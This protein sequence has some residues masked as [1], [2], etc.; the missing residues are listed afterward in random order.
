V[1]IFVHLIANGDVASLVLFGSLLVLVFAGM[2]SI[3][4]KRKKT[5]GRHWDSYAATT[6]IIPFRAIKE[7]RNTLVI[8]EFKVWQMVVTL[9]I[10]LAVM[11]FH[12]PWFGGS[13][14]F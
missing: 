13:P 10:Y 2:I 11:H 1:G 7:G 14:L 8:A 3:D 12:Q 4:G 5:C 9:L 6:S